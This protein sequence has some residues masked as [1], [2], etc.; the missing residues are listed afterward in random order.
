[1]TQQEKSSVP[2]LIAKPALGYAPVTL[3]ATT[4]A[5][6]PF[7]RITAIAA[8]PGPKPSLHGLDFPAP[9]RFC[10]NANA[11]LA[12]SGRDQALLFGAAAPEGLNAAICDQSDAWVTLTLSGP[13]ASDVL[14]RLVPLD[15]RQQS[16]GAS[17]RSALN[18]MPLLLIIEAPDSFR[19]L[20]FRSMARSAWHE[21]HQ[22]M[23]H[24][25]ARNA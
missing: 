22:A 23:T 4:L 25:A 24:I 7:T 5:E 12:W 18:H 16:R 8:F 17:L 9:N 6:A 1:M 11:R 14:A 15:L 10:E 13:D 19:L 3:G 2:D 21:I 20:T